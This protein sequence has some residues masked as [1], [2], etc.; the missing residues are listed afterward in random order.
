[1]ISVRFNSLCA[2]S[3]LR[4]PIEFASRL[5]LAAGR[6]KRGAAAGLSHGVAAAAIFST[7]A[8]TERARPFRS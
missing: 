4:S 1:M 8:A 3:I 5:G 2:S 7:C 6:T